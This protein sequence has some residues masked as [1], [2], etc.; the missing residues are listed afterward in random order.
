MK[1]LAIIG[2]A[3][4]AVCVFSGGVQAA[5]K[6]GGTTSK[7]NPLRCSDSSG[8]KGGNCTWWAWKMASDSWYGGKGKGKGIPTSDAKLWDNNAD[9][10]KFNVTKTPG[11][12][13]IGVKESS[14]YCVET[15]TSGKNKGKC[16]KYE[17]HGHVA[18]IIGKDKDKWKISEMFWGQNGVNYRSVKADYF[19]SYIGKK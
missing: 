11:A 4:L 2:I 13:T 3:L 12:N 1:N 19:D 5:D 17:D 18:W 7:D 9:R 6:C 14:P 16:K 8:K 15:Y 10:K